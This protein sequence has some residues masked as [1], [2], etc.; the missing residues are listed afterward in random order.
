MENLSID[1]L[2][3]EDL[4]SGNSGYVVMCEWFYRDILWLLIKMQMM[5]NLDTY[6]QTRVN[7]IIQGS[8]ECVGYL[9]IDDTVKHNIEINFID[10]FFE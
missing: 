8:L 1:T 4:N 10:K 3:P 2:K 5:S 9:S 6:T 7:Q